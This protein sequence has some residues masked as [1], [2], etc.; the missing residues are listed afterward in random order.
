[1]PC[2]PWKPVEEEL[3]V[4]VEVIKIKENTHVIIKAKENLLNDFESEEFLDIFM[5]IPP[6]LNL[7]FYGILT[8]NL[9]LS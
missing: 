8:N 6:K 4:N 3:V 2:P 5:N 7:Q 9:I 1:M